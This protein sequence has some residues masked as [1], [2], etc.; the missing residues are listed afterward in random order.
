MNNPGDPA[1]RHMDL[2]TVVRHEIGHTLGLEHVATGLMDESLSPGESRSVATAADPT[3]KAAADQPAP[4]ASVPEDQPA[5]ADQPAAT[6]S[7]PARDQPPANQP[8]ART[9]RRRLRRPSGQTSPLPATRLQSATGSQPGPKPGSSAGT[10]PDAPADAG[11][12]ARPAANDTSAGGAEPRWV[13]SGDTAT[14]RI[15][16]DRALRGRL[17]FA[18]GAGRLVFTAADGTSTSVSLAG[19]TRLVVQ[20][21]TG[22]DDI[23]V[24]LANA[25]AVS[26]EIDGGSGSDTVSFEADGDT[27]VSVLGDDTL[28]VVSGDTTLT[29]RN[30]E[31][32]VDLAPRVITVSGAGSRLVATGDG[33]T[34]RLVLSGLLSNAVLAFG[35]PLLR[36]V[37]DA[38]GGSITVTGQ[39]SWSGED[40]D[41]E[42]RA[43]NIT[44]TPGTVIDTGT[45]DLI[46]HASDTSPPGSDE[47]SAS[48]TV[49]GATI[50]GGNLVF[51]ADST[52]DVLVS[53]TTAAV[54][55]SSSATVAVVDSRL[56]AGGDISLLSTSNASASATATGSVDQTDA[57]HEAATATVSLDSLSSALIGGAS[58]VVAGGAL[59]IHAT[60]VTDAVAVAS[61]APAAAGA[62]V[63]IVDVDRDTR[64]VIETSGL[65]GIVAAVLDILA[66]AT[67]TLSATATG[68]TGGATANDTQVLTSTGPVPVVSTLGVGLLH[69]VTEAGLGGGGVTIRTSSNQTVRA[70]GGDSVVVISDSSATRGPGVAAAI[71]LSDVATRAF[72]AG[73]LALSAPFVDVI[74]DGH[75]S[76]HSRA[77][78]GTA[79]AAEIGALSVARARLD[80]SS[81]LAPGARLAVS[82]TDVDFAATSQSVST[83]DTVGAAPSVAVLVVDHTTEAAIGAG[84]DLVGAGSVRLTAHSSRP[85]HL[86]GE[87]RWRSRRRADPEHRDHPGGPRH[88]LDARPQRRPRRP[89]GPGRVGFQ[90]ATPRGAGA[91]P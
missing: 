27:S 60:N 57:A 20:G 8:P 36:A 56:T 86:Y 68:S 66:S 48:V 82:G 37:L 42:M 70:T 18:E 39:L 29:A 46:L 26:V 87:C 45:G 90:H 91:R 65:G 81:A 76:L 6:S 12:P 30:V 14:L 83:S 2:L 9:S 41:L 62:G 67:G 22:D 50:S 34:G 35:A 47:A 4:A 17:H 23:D 72:L 13:V 58:M 74:A 5:T 16:G 43:R 80:T 52:T 49:T 11:R 71:A 21:S 89:G 55:A 40:G 51:A 25:G 63:A 78:S 88:R 59:V 15:P 54:N 10:G 1:A 79:P 84:A 73:E 31:S 33:L 75:S 61:A 19:I 77:V 38:S 32:L 64:A 69:G 24:D 53:G 85:V 44:V 28:R 3:P 7:R